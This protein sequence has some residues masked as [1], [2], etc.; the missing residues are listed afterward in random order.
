[1][2]ENSKKILQLSHSLSLSESRRIFTTNDLFR[3]ELSGG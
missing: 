3:P 2:S 1:M